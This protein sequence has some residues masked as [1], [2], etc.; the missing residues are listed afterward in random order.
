MLQLGF[1]ALFAI[2]STSQSTRR[3]ARLSS[4]LLQV[5]L[6]LFYV[7]LQSLPIAFANLIVAF[8][9]F[10][11]SCYLS[12]SLSTFLPFSLCIKYPPRAQERSQYLLPYANLISYLSFLYLRHRNRKCN[13]VSII[14]HLHLSMS[15]ALI[16]LR[17]VL[18]L[19]M[20]VRSQ[21]SIAA[22]ILLSALYSLIVCFPSS[23]LSIFQRYLPIVALQNS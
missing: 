13:T 21:T 4:K 7:C 19:N 10:T 9:T 22:T 18:S 11:S 5:N 6:V 3:S 20:F 12:F 16:L 2:G 8:T 14:L 17:Y 15:I 1:R 23:A